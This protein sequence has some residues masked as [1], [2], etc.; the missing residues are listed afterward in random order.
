M[1]ALEEIFSDLGIQLDEEVR[2]T[3]SLALQ[4]LVDETAAQRT[5]E[6]QTR[7]EERAEEL[8]ATRQ[9]QAL[10]A[11]ETAN[12]KI[13]ALETGRIRDQALLALYREKA[14]EPEAA[15]SLLQLDELRF[16][17]DGGVEGLG[18]QISA[19]KER[20]GALFARPVV[21]G[22]KGNFIRSSLSAPACSLSDALA[23]HYQIHSYYR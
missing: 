20:E 7:Q 19:L 11:Q 6:L 2:K 14:V 15:L 13:E 16:S 9:A 1:E 4:E 8:H 21:T 23:E 5:A 17:Q 10:A 3:L 12:A 18:E 22:S